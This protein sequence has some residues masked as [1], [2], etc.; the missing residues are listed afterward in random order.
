[1][2]VIRDRCDRYTVGIRWHVASPDTL[3]FQPQS[4]G[5]PMIDHETAVYAPPGS[6]FFLSIG[7]AEAVIPVRIEDVT[8]D[9]YH[10]APVYG[11]SA[12]T[13]SP[14]DIHE[15]PTQASEYLAFLDRKHGT[16]ANRAEIAE[17]NDPLD[18]MPAPDVR[19]NTVRSRKMYKDGPRIY[20]DVAA[21]LKARSTGN[22]MDVSMID[23][24]SMIVDMIQPE[25]R[26]FIYYMITR[27][28]GNAAK[29][30]RAV[31]AGRARDR[32]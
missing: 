3:V 18:D 11:G 31:Y 13:V 23:P 27:H 20:S 17:N 10:V 7:I 6:I 21:S 9:G 14:K 26:A 24:M 12:R 28:P 29:A 30:F 2:T 32:M 22:L 19:D 5:V 1:M 16:E 25:M 8:D 4:G 15:T